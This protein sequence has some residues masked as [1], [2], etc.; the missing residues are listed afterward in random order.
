MHGSAAQC[1]INRPHQGQF[2]SLARHKLP[3][4]GSYY[5]Q[6]TC[7]PSAL[8]GPGSQFMCVGLDIEVELSSCTSS[9]SPDHHYY[10]S[11]RNKPSLPYCSFT[12]RCL[13]LTAPGPSPGS[14]GRRPYVFLYLR[15][16][17]ILANTLQEDMQVQCST[18]IAS[19]R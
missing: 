2:G 1:P 3:R 15:D 13:L 6:T 14:A 5:W 16:I 8:V 4:S 7:R 11:P 10:N 18:S 9:F 12:S 17:S 19:S